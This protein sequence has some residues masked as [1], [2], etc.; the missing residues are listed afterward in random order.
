MIKPRHLLAFIHFNLEHFLSFCS[1]G[2][3]ADD[4]RQI[5]EYLIVH[6]LHRQQGLERRKAA[7]NG[8]QLLFILQNRGNAVGQDAIQHDHQALVRQCQLHIRPCNDDRFICLHQAKPGIVAKVRIQFLEGVQRLADTDARP[9][10]F[11]AHVF[12]R[13]GDVFREK[14]AIV[15]IGGKAV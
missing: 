5:C 14:R 11:D 9:G 4:R 10:V 12:Q 1:W 2:I 3:H 13:S 6:H 7:K 15:N 8:K